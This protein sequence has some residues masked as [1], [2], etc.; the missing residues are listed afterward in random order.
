LTRRVSLA[1]GLA[2]LPGP[3]GERFATV[4][5]HGTLI[6]EIYAPRGTDPQTPHTRDEVYVVMSGSGWFV[7]GPDRHRFGTG[8]VLFVPAGVAHRF[9]EF[10][11]DLALWAMF[12]TPQG[13]N[14]P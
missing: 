3:A 4:I 2:R 11:D 6:V 14:A 13:G 5:E 12:C 8:D 7:N 10:S 9:E 1:E